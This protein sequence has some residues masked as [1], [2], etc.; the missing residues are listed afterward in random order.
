MTSKHAVIYL[1]TW[2]PQA[3]MAMSWRYAG[4]R[5]SIWLLN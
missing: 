1:P 2:V 4:L 3:T 5:L